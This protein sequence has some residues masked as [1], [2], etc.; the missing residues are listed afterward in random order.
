MSRRSPSDVSN[1]I[2]VVHSDDRA[3]HPYDRLGRTVTLSPPPTE[4]TSVDR[5]TLAHALEAARI[6]GEVATPR[7][8]NLSHTPRFLAPGRQFDF[9][10]ELTR[11][12]ANEAVCG[13]MD[14][15]AGRR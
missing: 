8:T 2:A 13:P 10:A 9:G 4:R 6:T 1:A 3:H 12:W 7:E 5:S 15:R 11:A 14:E